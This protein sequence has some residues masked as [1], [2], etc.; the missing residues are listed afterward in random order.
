MSKS[1]TDFALR[2]YTKDGCSICNKPFSVDEENSSVYF[3]TSE[4][5][6]AHKHCYE[7]LTW[8]DAGRIS[9]WMKD[10]NKG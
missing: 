3:P 2:S 5:R 9:V 7:K 8:E 10:L 4:G 6:A 1:L